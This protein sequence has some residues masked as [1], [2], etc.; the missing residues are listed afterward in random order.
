MNSIAGNLVVVHERF[1]AMVPDG[2][3][4]EVLFDGC[5]FSE[6]PVWF[7]DLNCLLWSDIPNDRLMRWTPDGHVDLFRSPSHFANGN[8]RDREGRLVTCEHGSRRVTRTE[9]DGAITVIADRYEGR[10][11]NSPN[12]VVVKSDGS[13]WFTD[14]GYG[15]HQ[16]GKDAKSEQA[17]EFV[18]RV[19]LHDGRVAIVVDDFIKPNGLCFSP[20]EKTLY[21]IDSAVS[22]GP[23]FPSHIRSFAVQDDGTLKGGHVFATTVGI[24]DGLRVDTAGNVWSSAGDGINCYTPSGLLLGRIGLPQPVTN[25]TFGGPLRNRLFITAGT[26]LYALPVNAVGAQRP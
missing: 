24:P 9:L 10:R 25:L 8:T 20:D 18:Y 5:T 17:G 2:G 3:K 22:E 15:L 1:R 4:V 6:G 21:I 14:P 13:I 11:F 7:A 19:D 26:A 12:D 16:S 23:G